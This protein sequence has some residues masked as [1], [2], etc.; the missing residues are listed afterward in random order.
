MKYQES[1]CN[2]LD[3]GGKE[4][5]EAAVCHEASEKSPKA[6][7]AFR[8]LGYLQVYSFEFFPSPMNLVKISD[9]SSV[10]WQTGNLLF[11][12]FGMN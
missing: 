1:L 12:N 3:E 8:R 6:F 4:N 7:W 11:Y 5:L 10:V 9:T 2:L